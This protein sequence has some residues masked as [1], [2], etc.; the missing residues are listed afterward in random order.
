MYLG[1]TRGNLGRK[2][3][4]ALPFVCGCAGWPCRSGQQTPCRQRLQT[5]TYQD[6]PRPNLWHLVA[7]VLDLYIYLIMLLYVIV[8]YCMWLYVVVWVTVELCRTVWS[9]LPALW[10]IWQVGQTQ[11]TTS[12]G[13]HRSDQQ[14]YMAILRPENPKITTSTARL[15]HQIPEYSGGVYNSWI[16]MA[17]RVVLQWG[18]WALAQWRSSC[19]CRW[20]HD[21][22]HWG[23]CSLEGTQQDAKC[24][25]PSVCMTQKQYL[26]G[27][28]LLIHTNRH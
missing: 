8:Y 14:F 1:G 23:L 12:E 2:C 6:I 21:P 19:E 18:D 3:R 13:R 7:I 15:V 9:C 25:T 11:T 28:K 4:K 16:P 26:S 17:P 5:W 24:S 20:C 27:G 10:T 22:S